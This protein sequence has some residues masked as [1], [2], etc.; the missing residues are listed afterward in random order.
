MPPGM[1]G[2]QTAKCLWNIS[3]DLQIVICTA[4]SDY[5]WDELMENLGRSDRFLVLKKP[6]ENIEVAQMAATLTAKWHVLQ[7][8]QFLSKSMA[9]LV[10]LRTLELETALADYGRLTGGNLKEL[11]AQSGS[12]SASF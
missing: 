10:A 12:D 8:T 3:P 7:Q 1:D 9:E 6:F 4:F 5:S 11:L 2:V